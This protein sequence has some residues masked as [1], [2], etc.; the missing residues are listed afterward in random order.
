MMVD[1]QDSTGNCASGV[2]V[3]WKRKLHGPGDVDGGDIE[4]ELKAQ[5]GPDSAHKERTS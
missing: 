1:Y 2:C 4:V 5:Q 3:Q